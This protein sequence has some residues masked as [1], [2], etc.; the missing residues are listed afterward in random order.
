MTVRGVD[1]IRDQPMERSKIYER[2]L[3]AFVDILGWSEACKTESAQLVEA[4][5]LIHQTAEGYS[6]QEKAKIAEMANHPGMTLN[7]MY[8]MVH[9]A[10]FSDSIAVSMPTSF[11]H[12]ILGGVT[13][14]CRNLLRLGFL[15]R[16]GITI[17]DLYHVENVIFGPALVEAVQLEKEAVYPRL[18]CSPTLVEFLAEYKWD[19]RSDPIVSDHLGRKIANLFPVELV[20]S[21]GNLDRSFAE[22][23]WKLSDIETILNREIQKF[24]EKKSDK[25][26]EKWRYM[27]DVLPIMLKRFE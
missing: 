5:E 1:D 26:T 4:A 8:K 19:D 17:G 27:R 16:G 18:V 13:D 9:M 2:R 15:T 11:G 10:A 12:R 7:P 14:L 20:P 22:K 24:T 21:T 25:L 23:L 3:V 6:E